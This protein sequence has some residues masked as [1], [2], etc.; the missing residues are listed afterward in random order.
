MSTLAAQQQQKWE[1]IESMTAW[2]NYDDGRVIDTI[3]NST[4]QRV[5]D[6]SINFSR[7]PLRGG[8]TEMM[9]CGLRWMA[10]ASCK[11]NSSGWLCPEAIDIADTDREEL[12]VHN[13]IIGS[14]NELQFLSCSFIKLGLSIARLSR[15]GGVNMWSRVVVILLSVVEQANAYHDAS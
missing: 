9:L 15:T 12:S 14:S 1:Q 3:I 4:I 10:V 11:D 5:I 13:I 2:G 7:Y 6:K 8:V